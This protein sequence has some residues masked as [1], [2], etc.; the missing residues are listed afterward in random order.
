MARIRKEQAKQLQ[1]ENGVLR[2]KIAIY[3]RLSKEDGNDE[4]LS[5]TQQRKILLEYV[6]KNFTEQ[7]MV[8]DVYCDDG[9]SGTDDSRNDFQRMMQDVYAGK[10]NC[11]VCKTLSRAF[12]NYADQGRYLEEIFPKY[13]VRFISESNPHVDSH[14]NADAIQN[15]LEIPINGLMNDRFA[16]KT[17][18]DIRRTFQAKRSRGEFTGAFAPYGYKK[19]PDNKNS[20]LIDEEAAAVVKNIFHWYVYG[21]GSGEGGMSKEGIAKK[22]NTLGVPN[23]SSYKKQQGLRYTGPRANNTD[24]MW[25]GC[26]ITRTLQ[27]K[28]YIGTMVQGR[29][30]MISYKVHQQIRVPEDEWVQ[31]EHAHQAIVSDELFQLAE[32]RQLRETRTAP[33]KRNNYLF[34]GFLRCADCGQAMT[35]RTA[36]NHVYYNCTTY[37]RKS[38]TK[39]TRHTIRLDA[40]EAAVL[41]SI[42]MQIALTEGLSELIER[43]NAAPIVRKSSLRLEQLLATRNAELEKV[44]RISLELYTDWKTGELTQQQYHKMK[45]TFAAQEAQLN[46]T[47]E[48][49]QAEMLVMQNG[50]DAKDPFFKAFEA[51]KNITELSQEVL[52]ALVDCIY[53]HEGGRLTIQ[54]KLEDQYKRIVTFVEEN[55]LD[56]SKTAPGPYH[57]KVRKS[58]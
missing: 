55:G 32:E 45:A 31:I 40:L 27:N 16:A 4:S 49:I 3:I 48:N 39:C 47:I 37:K 36:K 58:A 9:K 57:S 12:R 41:Q 5:I 13:G 15:G 34:A 44:Q 46:K 20:F 23:P 53:I 17:S 33:G 52:T 2:W 18:A 56:L 14:L 26:A 7:H 1:Q 11:V 10:V 6:D 50:V 51:H 24:G 22:L 29:Q 21:D 30:R 35:R 38:K 42:Q 19:N 43:I 8:V 25:T 54:F 28:M